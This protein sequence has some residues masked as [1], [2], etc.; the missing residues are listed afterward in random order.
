MKSHRLSPF[1]IRV[2][3]FV[4]LVSGLVRSAAAQAN[5]CWVGAGATGV[6][7]PSSVSLAVVNGPH[8]YISDT[9]SLPAVIG[10]RYNVT[11]IYEASYTANSTKT[12]LVRYRDNGTQGRILIYLKQLNLINGV[13]A[14]LVVFDSDLLPQSNDF[15]SAQATLPCVAGGAFHFLDYLYFLRVQITR[16]SAA[17]LP[18][19]N[20]I[21]VCGAPCTP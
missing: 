20:S 5:Y 16:T 8:L 12:M 4:L 3:L 15:Q 18:N 11:G 7:D 17:G 1:W 2:L 9:V 13:V 10:S 6:L 14:D 21:Q 19:L